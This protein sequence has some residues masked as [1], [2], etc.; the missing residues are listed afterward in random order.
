MIM[1]KNERFEKGHTKLFPR[2]LGAQPQVC[3]VDSQRLGN[4]IIRNPMARPALKFILKF[5]IAERD[6]TDPHVP[7]GLR[8]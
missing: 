1:G 8:L 7:P 2:L 5:D 6:G 3:A 4:E